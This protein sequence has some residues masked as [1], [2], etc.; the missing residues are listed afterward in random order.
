MND[1][2]VPALLAIGGGVVLAL[3]LFVPYVAAS[4]RRRGRVGWG[5]ALLAA[6][7][8]VYA[9]ALVTYTLLPLPAS[10]G[11]LCTSRIARAGAQLH[12]F[13]F[14]ADIATYDMA[15]PL[16]NPAALQVLFN[17]AL[18]VP[19]GALLRHLGRR[20]VLTVTLAGAAVSALIEVT[21]LTGVWFL[22]P[23]PYRLFDVD[24]LIA[25]TAGALLG[26]LVAPLLRFVPGQRLAGEPG[27]PRPVTIPRRLLGVVCD[28][29]GAWLTGAL[30]ATGLA[31]VVLLAGGDGQA[32]WVSSASTLLGTWV[33]FALL[34]VLLPMRG[35]GGTPGQRAVL[36]RPALRD[37]GVPGRAVL[38]AR[39]LLG[40]GGYVL[41]QGL[42]SSGGWA[43]LWGLAGLIGILATADRRGLGGALTSTILLDR[44]AVAPAERGD[45]ASA[46]R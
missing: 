16:R 20:S 34:F 31:A 40:T 17:V 18:F 39:S 10:D 9:L 44:R 42:E 25:N 5:H 27:A 35:R 46:R 29:L 6:S 43:G 26:G 37:G 38:L 14:V 23:C 3:A 22:Y 30:L 1:P 8:L 13:A 11:T 36:L 2:L 28:L 33:P 24:D 41:L 15:N 19:L 45:P 4:Y 21:Q 12:P 32:P 7:S